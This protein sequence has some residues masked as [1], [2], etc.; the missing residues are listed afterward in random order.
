MYQFFL[1]DMMLPV[2]PRRLRLQ[3]NNQ[4]QTINLVSG[5][6]INLLKSPGL[7]E[8]TFPVLLPIRR[9]PFAQYADGF[10]PPSHF[11]EVM[12]TL[13]LA[14]EPFSFAVIRTGENGQL[15]E[16]ET[17]MQ[18]SLEDYRVTEGAEEAMDFIV[19]VKLKQFRDFGTKTVTIEN[20]TA[21]T[22]EDRPAPTAPNKTQRTY[23]VVSGDTLR[24]IAAR[25]LGDGE[26]H[27]EL[28]TLNE[29]VIEAAAR[30][31]GL[32]SSSN[33]QWIFPGTVIRLPE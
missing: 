18:V 13:K 16:V 32:E 11:L 10:R 7:S 17:S 28:F 6:E 4:N 23:T 8:F 31:R 15:L 20:G 12:E 27:R 9:Y 26:R 25:K 3:I 33:G 21:T 5:E 1:G 14:L 2:A 29:A 19:D 22:T 30:E 24:G